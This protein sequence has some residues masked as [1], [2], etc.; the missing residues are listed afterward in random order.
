[1]T[2]KRIPWSRLGRVG[3]GEAGGVDDPVVA[4]QAHGH[5]KIDVF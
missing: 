2:L 1:M 3:E 5:L 4:D